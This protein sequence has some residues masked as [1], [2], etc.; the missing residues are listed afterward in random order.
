MTTPRYVPGQ[1]PYNGLP[2]VPSGP[3]SYPYPYIPLPAPTSVPFPKT[4]TAARERQRAQD[5]K[6]NYYHY[7]A[8]SSGSP[9]TP[10]NVCLPY[11][12][13]RHPRAHSIFSIEEEKAAESGF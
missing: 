1:Q 6:F 2:P 12:L 8:G 3:N 4:A 13:P 9:T 5:T 11:K 10:N 7:G